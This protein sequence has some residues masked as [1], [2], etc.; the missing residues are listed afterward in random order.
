[1]G[2]TLIANDGVSI[3]TY[4]DDDLEAAI[5]CS[6]RTSM[7]IA[8]DLRDP[9]TLMLR[10]EV[11]Y[12]FIRSIRGGY[13]PMLRLQESKEA[14]LGIQVEGG[15]MLDMLGVGDATLTIKGTYHSMLA[16]LRVGGPTLT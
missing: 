11:V 16:W 10:S 6:Q 2:A 5:K 13:Y 12:H 9:L 14:T 4:F 7:I 1:M 3:Y 15:T 8:Y